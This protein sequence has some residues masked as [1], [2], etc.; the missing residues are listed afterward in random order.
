MMSVGV[1]L[2]WSS[3]TPFFTTVGQYGFVSGSYLQ[4]LVFLFAVRLLL[5]TQWTDD[6]H[7]DDRLRL[8]VVII[9]IIIRVYILFAC[10]LL[11]MMRCG[12]FLFENIDRMEK[13][14]KA[15][16][17]RRKYLTFQNGMA[18]MLRNTGVGHRK[19]YI[20]KNYYE[21]IPVIFIFTIE[22]TS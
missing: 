21:K 8:V 7:N 18:C 9:I 13:S 10:T 11:Q 12:F 15:N 4:C 17:R 6:H 14:T 2:F 22:Y 3:S 1:L 19:K 5:S 20:H 16:Q